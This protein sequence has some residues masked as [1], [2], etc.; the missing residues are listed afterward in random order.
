MRL[1]ARHVGII[2]GRAAVQRTLPAIARWVVE[3][4]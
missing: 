1:P 3:R 4:S 2:Y